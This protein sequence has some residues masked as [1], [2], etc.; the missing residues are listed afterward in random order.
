MH[1]EK[2]KYLRAVRDLK[3]SLPCKQMKV[4]LLPISFMENHF[5]EKEHFCKNEYCCSSKVF[6]TIRCVSIKYFESAY[7]SVLYKSPKCKFFFV[8]TSRQSGFSFNWPFFLKVVMVSLA[9]I[10]VCA[11]F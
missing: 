6:F 2:R 8:Q 3:K 11:T 4:R 10:S 5:L 7:I 1:N 9:K